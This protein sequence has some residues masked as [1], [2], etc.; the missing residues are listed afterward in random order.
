MAMH[1]E[2]LPSRFPVGTK[3]VLEGC[4][5]DKG[6]LRIHSRYVEFPDGRYVDLL[7]ADRKPRARRGPGVRRKH[8][9]RSPNNR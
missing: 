7:G 1:S 3:F 8:A 5:D 6:R 2:G 9:R 4:R